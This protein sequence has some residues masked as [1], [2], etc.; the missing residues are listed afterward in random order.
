MEA[1]SFVEEKLPLPSSTNACCETAPEELALVLAFVAVDDDKEEAVVED[2][3]D[4]LKGG[5]DFEKKF[6]KTS[7]N[8]S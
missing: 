6:Y 4:D 1:V 3:D 8:Y 7:H 5:C 2:D